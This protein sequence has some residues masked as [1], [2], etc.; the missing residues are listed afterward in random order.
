MKKVLILTL[1]SLLLTTTV[2]AGDFMDTQITFTYGD[3]N[4]F[5]TSRRSPS[6]NFGEREDEMFN[7]N[8]NTYKTGDETETMLVVYK[9]FQGYMPLLTIET[10]FVM[11]LKIYSN[12]TGRLGSKVLEDG[13][14]IRLK[15]G[16]NDNLFT[17]TAFPYDSD[18]FLLGWT[19]DLSWG[20]QSFWPKSKINQSTPVPGLKL[21]WSQNDEIN[22]FLGFKTRNTNIEVKDED[23]QGN[24]VSN[25][26]IAT[27]WA[28]MSGGFFD[29]KQIRLDLHS[30]FFYKGT[31]QHQGS[32]IA[33]EDNVFATPIYAKGIAGRISFRDNFDL[34]V[35]RVMKVY[36]NDK[37]D[38]IELGKEVVTKQSNNSGYIVSLEGVYLSEPLRDADDGNALTNFN[39]WAFDF[40]V[41]MYMSKM[42]FN[43]DVIMRNVE[44]LLFN[45]PGLTAYESITSH[46]K[47]TNELMISL[48]GEY[49][50]KEHLTMGFLL[51]FKNPAS[52]EGE[53]TGYKL[54]IKD[55]EDTSSFTGG[56]RKNKVKMPLGEAVRPIFSIKTSI[57]YELAE[58]VSFTTE[59]FFVR[60]QN[61][62]TLND[63][64]E[65]V[66]RSD[67]ETNRLGFSFIL[68][69]RF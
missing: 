53:E 33:S 10:A 9:K 50:L 22:F 26:T 41:K 7:E 47:L 39:A 52:Y 12:E 48:G 8:L 13:S 51:G 4:V 16:T 61:D 17:L 5:E 42:K 65:R 14:Y 60:D 55:R 43:L 23:D 44:F 57:I 34:A 68:Q 27:T 6:A 28:I 3:D 20:G 2:V 29:T 64:N 56:L 25:D 1:L 35:S 21:E 18:R 46:A 11:N 49:E 59:L 54:V 69:S 37:R 66:L 45:V 24:L 62:T 15:Y 31:N 58:G 63:A 36:A 32:A 38:D 40:K 67:S 30:G 19:Y